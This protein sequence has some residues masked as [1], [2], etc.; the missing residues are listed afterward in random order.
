ME[1]VSTLTNESVAGFASSRELHPRDPL[2]AYEMSVLLVVQVFFKL[3][4]RESFIYY[5]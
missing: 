4:P 1:L 5:K 3:F 2:P